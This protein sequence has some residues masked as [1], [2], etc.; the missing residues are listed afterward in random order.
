MLLLALAATA[1]V[2][3]D[4]DSVPLRPASQD[5]VEA[6]APRSAEGPP[7]PA[8][9]VTGAPP[10]PAPHLLG[11]WGGLRTAL[12][13]RGVTPTLQYI[14]MP[15]WNVSGGTRKR[16]EYAAQFQV[17]ASADLG[18]I[19]GI[20]GGSLQVL[21]TN[22]HGRNL[23]ATAG[24]E[25]LQNP[26]AIFGAGQIWR[27]SQ[28][29]YRQRLGKAELK[30]GR[31]SI[32]EDF[33]TAPCF[34][35]SLYFCGIVPGHVTPDYWYNPPVSV[36]GARVR[37]ED[38]LGYTQVGLYER[39]PTNLREDRGFYLG[40]SGQTGALIPLERGFVVRLG[41]DARRT[42]TYKFGVW[43][44]TSRSTDLV[45]DTGGGHA[46]LSG[47]PLARQR[48]RWGAYFVARQ[49]LT[50]AREDGS[51]VVNVFLS[52]TLTD[53]R[54]NLIRSIAVA[55]ATW[56]GII[57]GRPRDE[58]GLAIGR[59]RINPR[60]TRVQGLQRDAG[61]TDR[62]PQRAEWAAELAYSIV[63]DPA[64]S[65]RPNL[66]LYR[67]PGGRSD[68]STVTVLGLGAFATF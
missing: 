22:R 49:Q 18:R 24:L 63:V 43:H 6:A 15:A 51:G 45:R 23:T 58:I 21:V 14:A 38:G 11:D 19:A 12:E 65:L 35:E 9:S 17:G 26:Q 68:R 46:A 67:H 7:R 48:G 2:N 31:M 47:L 25:V 60:L 37:V 32:G 33:G 59:T 52:G 61:L 28:L 34:F 40:T 20:E 41:G 27:L 44:D 57:P 53:A 16:V 30:L 42:G 10:P 50:A 62:T 55:G 3:A 66:Q 8:P 1:A 64:F 29:F 5:A 13:E 36:W 54:T 4:A 39:N 56:S